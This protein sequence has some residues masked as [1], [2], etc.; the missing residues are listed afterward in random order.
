MFW[1]FLLPFAGS[2]IK[3]LQL[4]QT[5]VKWSTLDTPRQP[6]SFPNQ[7]WLDWFGWNFGIVLAAL[8]SYCMVQQKKKNVSEEL[9]MACIYAPWRVRPCVSGPLKQTGGLPRCLS[10]MRVNPFAVPSKNRH[11]VKMARKVPGGT[12]D[13]SHR[14]VGDKFQG[15]AWT[16]AMHGVNTGHV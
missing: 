11:L 1:S 7:T 10:L 14:T 2:L 16:R 13:C 3:N 4:N 6:Q 9:G 8:N 5:W 12:L 15:Y